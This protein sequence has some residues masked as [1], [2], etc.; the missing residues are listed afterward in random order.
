[1]TCGDYRLVEGNPSTEDY[2]RLRAAV[3]WSPF[4]PDA[5]SRGLRAD[6]FGVALLHGSEVV[7]CGRVVGDGAVYFYLQDIIVLP[8][9]RN[10]GLGALIMD[11]VMG[12]IQREAA[13]GAFIG[14]MA[15]EGVERFYEPYGF[16]RRGEE[17]PGMGLRW[18]DVP[19]DTS[20][21]S[22]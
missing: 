15:A 4:Q 10:R 3:G 22:G 13:P 5:A 6:L 16:R 9:H 1:M 20:G 17:Q 2:Q 7:G 12:F 8:E 11:A 18:G 19:E 21:P 14:L